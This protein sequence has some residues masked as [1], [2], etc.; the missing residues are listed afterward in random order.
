M[1][2][3]NLLF[4]IVAFTMFLPTNAKASCSNAEKARLSSLIQNVSITYDYVETNGQVYFN[5]AITNLQPDFYIKDV[6][7]K[8]YHY[9]N[10]SNELIL[11]GYSPNKN[12][13]FDFY[14]TGNCNQKIGSN[15]IT[16]PAF[17]PYYNDP[18][19][20]GVSHSICQ[21]WVNITYD[22]NT[23][24]QEVNKIKQANIN[25]NEEIIEEIPLGIYDYILNFYKKYYFIILPVIILAGTTY[26][27][28]QR[29]KDSLF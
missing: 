24:V 8:Q 2:K 9:Y 6:V 11:I 26:I 13:R 19:C 3:R 1:F 18:I 7:K 14:G 27:I 28:V 16:L 5:I 23:F 17:N 29:K 22:Y 15:Y 20:I 21:K 12:Y 4:I 25:T 10:G